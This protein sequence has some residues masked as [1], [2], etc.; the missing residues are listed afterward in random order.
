MTVCLSI[1]IEQAAERLRRSCLPQRSHLAKAL[2][3]LLR[4][5]H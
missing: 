1:A 2:A 5:S 4:L 3:A